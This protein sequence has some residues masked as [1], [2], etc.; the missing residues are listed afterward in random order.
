MSEPPS[1]ES[2]GVATEWGEFNAW[3]TGDAIRRAFG[4]VAPSQLPSLVQAF[5]RGLKGSGPPIPNGADQAA[6]K[7]VRPK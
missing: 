7:E 4:E 2:G 1:F 6:E 3:K 5:V